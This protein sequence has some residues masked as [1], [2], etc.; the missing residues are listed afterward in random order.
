[1]SGRAGM[2]SEQSEAQRE[3]VRTH[4]RRPMRAGGLAASV[5]E[6]QRSAGN[7][8]VTQ[9]LQRDSGRALAP[10]IRAQMGERFGH[11]FGAVRIHEGPLAAEAANHLSAKAFTIGQHIAFTDGRFAPTTSD[12]RRLLTHE[13]A[14]VVQQSRGGSAPSL[15]PQGA[16]EQSAHAASAAA[17]RNDPGCVT[18]T[19]ASGVGV[20]R[21]KDDDL[22]DKS[23]ELSFDDPEFGALV[24]DLNKSEFGRQLE[25]AKRR[26]NRRLPEDKKRTRKQVDEAAHAAARRK[27]PPGKVPGAQIQHQTKTRD[28]TRKLPKGMKPLYVKVINENLLWLQSSK[29]LPSTLLHVDPKGGG[30][31]FYVDTGPR[32]RVGDPGLRRGGRAGRWKAERTYQ[33][34][35]KFMD[36]YLI[37]R[38]ARRIAEARKRAGL[39]PLDPRMLAIAAGEQARWEMAGE[40]GTSRSGKVID[41]AKG[42]TAAPAPAG[43]PREPTSPQANKPQAPAAPPPTGDTPAP[44]EQTSPQADKPAAPAAPAPAG[45]TPGPHEQT[46]PRPSG[47]P[48]PTPPAPVGPAPGPHEPTRPQAPKGKPSTPEHGSGGGSAA[49]HGATQAANEM[50]AL[51]R[52]YDTYKDEKEAG[53][54]MTHAAVS[55]GWTYLQNAN[56]IAGAYAGFKSSYEHKTTKGGQDKAEAA[57]GAGFEA[58]GGFL[59]PGNEV[60][61]A[62]NAG[63][64]LTD[65]V[66]DH[67]KRGDPSAAA[68]DHLKPAFGSPTAE[69]E[70]K[71][72]LPTFRTAVGVIAGATPSR[73]GQQTL[74]GGARA[75]YNIGK[76]IGGD[77]RG[78]DRMGSDAATGELGEAF[79]IWGMAADFVGNLGSGQGADVA[80]SKTLKKGEK[81][82]TARVGARLGDV[83]YQDVEMDK[84]IISDLRAGKNLV[85]AIEDAEKDNRMM[86]GKNAASNTLGTY[87]GHETVKFVA[88]QV[89][90]AEQ[91]AKDKAKAAETRVVNTVQSVENEVK[92]KISKAEDMAQQAPAEVKQFVDEAKQ[93]ASAKI[94]ELKEGFEA[95]VQEAKGL[96]NRVWGG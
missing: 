62:I 87:V 59:I 35:H 4:D 76:A 64:N 7:N 21:T 37:P 15:D 20:A 93:K 17:L 46:S 89:P 42:G 80:L 19:G 72:K 78:I 26:P 34:E 67:L 96:W 77:P 49:L 65:A 84:K 66:D 91:W 47:H 24:N 9:L 28:V 56:P 39:P 48:A 23:E 85:Q 30:T 36:N 5:L 8:A 74:G 61:Q 45:N 38:A 55:A 83:G 50:S 69:D 43:Q 51:L 44:H 16:L 10:G 88:R 75:Y 90:K 12:G 41:I 53:K 70:N 86:W 54:D 79:Q 25:D 33:T 6:L 2:T 92:E 68:D 27:P 32:G 40:S 95:K 63:A 73:M 11:D 57:L 22:K 82:D 71:D 52:A 14:H 31:R 1:M 60:D 94:D 29:N 58:L 18:V 81:S 13:L 3:D